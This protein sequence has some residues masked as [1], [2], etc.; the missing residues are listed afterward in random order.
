[1]LLIATYPTWG[2]SIFVWPVTLVL[3]AIAWVRSNRDGLFWLGV[4][5]NLV[6]VLMSVAFI[7][8]TN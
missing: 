3:S 4:G 5:S 2:L 7:V 6:L 1:V 8:Q